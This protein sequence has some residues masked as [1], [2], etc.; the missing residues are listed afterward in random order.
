MKLVFKFFILS[1]ILAIAFTIGYGFFMLNKIKELKDPKSSIIITVYDWKNTPY[2]F[3]VGHKNPRFTPWNNI[4]PYVKWAVILSEDAKFYRHKGVDYEALKGALKRN[5]EV[6]KYVKGGSTITQQLA[7]NL[8]LTREK[9]II[10]KFKEL[11]IAF[12]LE[13]ELSKTR[14]L[15]LYLNAVEYGPLVYGINNASYYYF[16]KHPLNL[17]PLESAILASLLPS[18]KIFNPFKNVERTEV[19]AKRILNRMKQAK[20]ITDE[21]F[22][23]YNKSDLALTVERKIEVKT[24]TQKNVFQ[25]ISSKSPEPSQ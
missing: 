20:I 12:L 15:E 14:I 16:N 7:K 9:S 23:I 4:S 24:T 2:S 18:P 21:E 3:I 6:G 19:R 13:R 1:I 17:N 8:F 22:E 25:N 5:L 10:R 11:I